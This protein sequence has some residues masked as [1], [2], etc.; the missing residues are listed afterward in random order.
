MDSGGAERVISSLA[1]SFSDFGHEI[2]IIML[3]KRASGSFYKLSDKIRLI[4]LTTNLSKDPSFLRK[5]RLLK[6]QILDIRPDVV[7]SFLSYVCIYTWW[8]LHG[9]RIPYIVSERNDPNSRGKIKQFLLN[10]SF[11]KSSGCVFQTDDAKDWYRNICGNKS[12]VIS[13]PVNLSFIPNQCPVPKKQVLYVGRYSEQKNCQLLIK[14]FLKFHE[15]HPD[16]CLMMYGD[17]FLE[18]ELV[19]LVKESKAEEYIKIKKSSKTWQE[20]EFDSSLFVLP[21]RY[22]GMPNVLAEALCLGIPSISTDCPIG[23]PKELKKIFPELLMLCENE[24][25]D[26]MENAMEKALLVKRQKFDIPKELDKTYIANKWLDF[27]Q[28][29]IKRE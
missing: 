29:A 18:S 26:S 15:R 9:T 23:G 20:D 2:S 1:N 19:S 8:S 28:G 27:I 7:I 3:A 14:T 11:K 4:G 25:L 10:I 21:S 6:K 16:Y 13:N 17:G 5:S 12:I 24:N 22:E